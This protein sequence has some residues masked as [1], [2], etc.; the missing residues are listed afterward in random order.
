M[1]I[2]TQSRRR[3]LATCSALV[4]AVLVR[5]AGRVANALPVTGSSPHPTP[6]AGIT[7]AKV[8][9]AAQLVKT[10]ELITLFDAVRDAPAIVDGIRCNCSCGDS[11]KLYSLLSCYEGDAMARSCAICQGQ[12]RLATRLHKLGRSLDEIRAAIDAKYA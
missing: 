5:P 4:A 10:P 3:F 11:Q 7:G 2:T 9:T 12:G 8:L 6:R 1:N